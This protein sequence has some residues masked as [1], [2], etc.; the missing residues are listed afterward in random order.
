M[1]TITFKGKEYPTRTFNVVSEGIDT[2]ITIATDSLSEA[3]M[4]GK[5]EDGEAID[6]EIY[7]YVEDEVILLSG[8]EICKEHLDI[9]M[10]FISEEL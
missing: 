10:E 3:L 6:N 1:K 2:Q 7:F 4:N 9:E 5:I 8:E